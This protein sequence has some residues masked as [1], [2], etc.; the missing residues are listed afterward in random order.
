MCIAAAANMLIFQPLFSILL[1]E[2]TDG[3]HTLGPQLPSGA[4]SRLPVTWA[5]YRIERARN[6]RFIF[7]DNCGPTGED[8]LQFD[9]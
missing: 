4:V 8:L 5:G 3:R 7:K 6:R 9:V 1:M 2:R